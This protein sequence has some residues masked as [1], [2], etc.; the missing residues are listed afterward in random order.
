MP[1]NWKSVKER[2][3]YSQK[4][5]GYWFIL[6][7]LVFLSLFVI[8][9]L[10]ITLYLSCTRYNILTPA[11]W[12]G[13]SNF[14]KL[15]SEGS[16]FLKAFLNTFMYVAGVIP[17]TIGIAL[18]LAMVLNKALKFIVVFRAIYYTP[19][20]T[21]MVA[22]AIVWSWIFNPEIGVANR[23]L[24]TLGLPTSEWL[25]NPNLT[26]F[27]IVVV[28]VWKGIG[29]YMLI[30]LA[31]LQGIPKYLYE[32]ARLDGAGRWSMFWHIT[33]PLLKPTTFFVFVVLCINSFQVF[34]QIYVMTKGG[35]MDAST[36]VVYRIFVNGFTFLRM[37]YASSMAVILFLVI[38]VFTYFNVRLLKGEVEYW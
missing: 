17:F 19:V 5:M 35:P 8:V 18:L 3:F 10:I 36:V 6:P 34:D 4:V 26:M 1:T 12:I 11:R 38:L 31:G 16:L 23:V 27:C 7:S 30:Y 14:V 15:F 22:V 21:S 9:P 37:G 24:E 28:A 29:Y 13:F 33:L 20:I 32:V 25:R 2:L